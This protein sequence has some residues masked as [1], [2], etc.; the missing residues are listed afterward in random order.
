MF[1]AIT[2]YFHSSST[3]EPKKTALRSL[4]FEGHSCNFFL[5]FNSPEDANGM[6]FDILGMQHEK[7]VHTI[8]RIEKTSLSVSI[9]HNINSDD[10]DGVI[11]LVDRID[12]KAVEYINGKVHRR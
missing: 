8:I 10:D 4:S 9:Q 11:D 3:D 7:T 12:K 6:M 1:A 5:D 2:K